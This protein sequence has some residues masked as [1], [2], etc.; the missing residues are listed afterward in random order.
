MEKIE[1]QVSLRAFFAKSWVSLRGIL[2]R[3]NLD[4]LC[5]F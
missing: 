4:L 5:G 3:S 1:G 2:R